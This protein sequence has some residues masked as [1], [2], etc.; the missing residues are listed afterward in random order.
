MPILAEVARRF[1]MGLTQYANGGIRPAGYDMVGAGAHGTGYAAQT[2]VVAVPIESKNVTQ[3]N[4]PIQGVKMEDALAF[5]ARKKR[6][7][8]LAGARKS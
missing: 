1:G 5:A 4:G 6:Q 2:T 3:F 8:R 7:Q